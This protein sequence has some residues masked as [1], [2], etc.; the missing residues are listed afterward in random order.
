VENSVLILENDYFKIGKKVSKMNYSEKPYKY[1]ISE[2]LAVFAP[3]EKSVLNMGIV[4]CLRISPTTW[5]RYKSIRMDDDQQIGSV[6]LDKIAKIFGCT[7]D[8]LK[9]YDPLEP[10]PSLA[11]MKQMLRAEGRI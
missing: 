1:K 3:A 8:D 11:E 9:N 5:H 10:Q 6:H 2:K 4:L 7:A